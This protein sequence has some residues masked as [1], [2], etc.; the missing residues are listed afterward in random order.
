MTA[1]RKSRAK[2]KPDTELEPPLLIRQAAILI[3]LTVEEFSAKYDDS[4]ATRVIAQ[5]G[6]PLR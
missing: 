4:F 5:G 1:K 6:F 3:G 2:T